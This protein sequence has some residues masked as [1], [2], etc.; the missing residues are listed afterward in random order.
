MFGHAEPWYKTSFYWPFH[1]PEICI[2]IIEQ[3]DQYYLCL[4]LEKNTYI[5]KMKSAEIILAM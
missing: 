2:S 3:H 5:F 4:S 1:P